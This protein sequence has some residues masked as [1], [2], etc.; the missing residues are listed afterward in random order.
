MQ[1]YH[2]TAILGVIFL[3]FDLSVSLRMRL[4]PRSHSFAM[5]MDA[6]WLQMTLGKSQ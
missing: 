3:F 4:I 5:A 6:T 2:H 1:I